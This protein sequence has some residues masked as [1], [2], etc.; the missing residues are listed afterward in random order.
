MSKQQLPFSTLV[1]NTT[2]IAAGQARDFP[3]ASAAGYPDNWV[4]VIDFVTINT[5]GSA[6]A[7]AAGS[8]LTLTLN[9]YWVTGADRATATASA[10]LWQSTLNT[11]DPGILGPGANTITHTFSNGLPAW[12]MTSG[13]LT[14]ASGVASFPAFNFPTIRSLACS[15]TTAGAGVNNVGWSAIFGYHYECPSERR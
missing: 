12:G 11:V 13:F 6:T 8:V 7:A 10:T 2:N 3:L 15:G 14:A 1:F 4:P 5:S 9:T